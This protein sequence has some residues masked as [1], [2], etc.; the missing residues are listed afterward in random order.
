LAGLNG[1]TSKGRGKEVGK[2]REGTARGGGAKGRGEDETH[3][4]T[5]P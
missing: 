5:P 1:P 4:F 2:G 3:P